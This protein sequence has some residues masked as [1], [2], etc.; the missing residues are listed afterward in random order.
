MADE[1]EKDQQGNRP[2]QPGENIPD[3]AEH[4]QPPVSDP[5]AEPEEEQQA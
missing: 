5:N 2:G 4:E 3:G 1:Q